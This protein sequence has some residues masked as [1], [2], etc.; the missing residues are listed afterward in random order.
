MTNLLK[1]LL[2]ASYATS[3][4]GVVSIFC[5]TALLIIAMYHPERWDTLSAQGIGLI[6]EL[7]HDFS[8]PEGKVEQ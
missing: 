5:G 1:S 4:G 8:P 2:G 7:A 6:K 3:L